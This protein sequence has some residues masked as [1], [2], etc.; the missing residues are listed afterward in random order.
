[1]KHK[2]TR[3][4][5]TSSNQEGAKN[6]RVHAPQLEY[7]HHWASG[8]QDRHPQ[9]G[10]RWVTPSLMAAVPLPFHLPTESKRAVRVTPE[11]V[12]AGARSWSLAACSVDKSVQRREKNK[13][14]RSRKHNRL[15]ME[16]EGSNRQWGKP[17]SPSLGLSY[18]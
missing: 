17:S 13:E 16:A 14:K 4:R 6:D 1:M 12:A 9:R 10:F 11:T 3:G 8:G 15:P 2:K 7:Q 18:W 5:Q